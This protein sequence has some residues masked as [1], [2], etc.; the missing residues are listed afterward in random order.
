MNWYKDLRQV[1]GSSCIFGVLCS[2]MKLESPPAEVA[3]EGSMTSSR[4][5]S[6]LVRVPLFDHLTRLGLVPNVLSLEKIG[7]GRK[8]NYLLL[9]YMELFSGKN[10]LQEWLEVLSVSRDR[11][12][13][14]ECWSSGFWAGSGRKSQLLE[15][16]QLSIRDI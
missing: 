4:S 1:Q 8:T 10:G 14:P 16:C 12:L 11:P 2:G 13:T 5:S 15:I 7:N 9:L 6:L 3:K